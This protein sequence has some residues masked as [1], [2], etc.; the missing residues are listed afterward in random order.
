MIEF[1]PANTETDD[2]DDTITIALTISRKGKPK[3][4]KPSDRA[5]EL[6]NTISKDNILIPSPSG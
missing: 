5:V 2:D 3:S 1:N 4:D 6:A